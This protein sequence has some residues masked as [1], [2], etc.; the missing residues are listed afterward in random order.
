MHNSID[1]K[2]N[3]GQRLTDARK[4]AEL[5]RKDLCDAVN[6]LAEN[7]GRAF[8]LN[9]ATL[10]QWEYGNNQINIEWLPYLCT[11]L[12]C[13]IGY[14]FG[15]YECRTR[16]ATDIRE[17][18]GLSELAVT[19]LL[20]AAGGPDEG[21]MKLPVAE[22]PRDNLR[23]YEIGRFAKIR[24]IEA[25]LEHTEE[26]ERLAV[27]AYDYRRQ[28][29]LYGFEPNDTVEGIRHDQFADVAKGNGKEALADLFKKIEWDV[30]NG[31]E[32]TGE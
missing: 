6:Q 30:F 7:D 17:E 5:S 8:F 13:D 29:Q 23:S 9:E 4:K 15:D 27:A 21:E 32:W 24:F 2:K 22:S 25:L 31:P 11:A 14:I 10:K 20:V 3:I 19:N 12:R 28:M 26:L 1:I 18:T 16:I